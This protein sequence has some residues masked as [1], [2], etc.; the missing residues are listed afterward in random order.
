MSEIGLMAVEDMEQE[1]PGVSGDNCLVGAGSTWERT[2]DVFEALTSHG[3][4]FVGRRVKCQQ[5]LLVRI[6]M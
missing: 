1:R 4:Q 5:L 3:S 2:P 6:I